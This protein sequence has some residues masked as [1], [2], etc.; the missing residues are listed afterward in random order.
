MFDRGG[1]Y[2]QI[3]V[4]SESRVLGAKTFCAFGTYSVN[5]ENKVLVMHIEASSSAPLAGTSQKRASIFLTATAMKYSN[6]VTAIG[7]IA[8]V[9]C[10]RVA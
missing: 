1:H 8:E 3:I 7:A 10:K 2:S 6:S 5:E 9:L 4:G